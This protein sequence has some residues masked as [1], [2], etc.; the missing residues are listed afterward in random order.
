MATRLD[1]R[2]DNLPAQLDAERHL[3]GSVLRSNAA[4]DAIAD[5]IDPDDLHL[6]SHRRLYATMRE[7]W[8]R[9]EPIALV[10]IASAMGAGELEAAGGISAITSLF[11]GVPVATDLEYY[12]ALVKE[13]AMRRKLIA[14]CSDIARSAYE[15][16]HTTDDVLATA[17]RTIMEIGD[18]TL[19]KTMH[20]VG[21]LLDPAMQRFMKLR[22]NKN[23][24]TGLS[25]GLRDLDKLTSGFQ[26]TDLIIV[27]G[28]PGMG[29]TSL[30]LNIAEHAA[31]V[32]NK[33]VLFYSLEMSKEQ[34]V[35]K[36]LSSIANVSLPQI[37]RGF[38]GQG[39][40]DRLMQAFN[41]VYQKPLFIDD[42]PSLTVDAIMAKCRRV[43][44]E[45]AR[46]TPPVELG[47]VI[48]DYL[49]L[50]V[51]KERVENRTQEVSNMS[52]GLKRLAKELGVPVVVLSQLNR[53]V[54]TRAK[55]ASD[56]KP[57]LSDLRESGAIEQDADLIIFVFREE[58]Y[59]PT[60]PEAQNIASLLVRKHRNGATGD[61]DVHFHK[62]AT[63]FSDLDTRHGG[64]PGGGGGGDPL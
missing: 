3:L 44:S 15:T 48:V 53:S 61:I 6:G 28:R 18:R 14:A 41:K 24:V 34:L 64:A 43:R 42:D 33:A 31:C 46:R 13:K 19:R 54:E 4:M 60:K 37:R 26:P 20:E 16:G 58:Y 23:L 7:L 55:S 9:N 38:V 51:S 45:L 35:D 11:E 27:A 5:H 52:R 50:M 39:E 10:T 62:E 2:L 59:D 49:Q 40:W 22:Q 32:E 29:K 57:Q 63:R 8:R 1:D 21:E 25:T 56:K 36:V 47:L 30:A 17:E 12:V